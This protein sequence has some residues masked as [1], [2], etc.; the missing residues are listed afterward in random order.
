M[1][2]EHKVWQTDFLN[3]PLLTCFQ[4]GLS[5]I[6]CIIYK[7]ANRYAVT[8]LLFFDFCLWIPQI[9]NTVW[10]L[11]LQEGHWGPGVCSKKGKRAGEGSGPQVL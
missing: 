1:I 6:D 5:S 7:K 4:F 3:F 2:I 11:T 8:L 9:G 10:S